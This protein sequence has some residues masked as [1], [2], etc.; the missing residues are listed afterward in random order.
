MFHTATILV[1]VV[2]ISLMVYDYW[3]RKG[4]PGQGE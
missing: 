1:I 4:G 3:R 2:I